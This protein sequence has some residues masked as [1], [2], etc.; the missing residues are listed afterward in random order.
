MPDES[1]KPTSPAEESTAKHRAVDAERTGK[2][3]PVGRDEETAGRSSPAAEPT[4][5]FAPTAGQYHGPPTIPGYDIVG[6]LGRGG[7]G[8]VC[9]AWHL[10]TKRFVALKTVLAG[11]A[12]SPEKLRRFQAEAEAVARLKHPNIIQFYEAGEHEGRPFFALEFCGGGT[13]AKKLSGNP[14]TARA[15]AVLVEKL[16]QAVASAHAA[17]VIHRDLKPAN[18]LLSSD[19]EPKIGD[20][21]LA[22]RLDGDE[23]QTRAGAVIGTP[24][25]MPP[26]QAMA[27]PKAA[28]PAADIYALGAILYECLTGRAPFRGATAVDTLDQVRH[29]KPVPPRQ[30][31]AKIP[32]DL[33]TICLKCL[34]KEPAKRYG[35]AQA[36][37]EDLRRFLDGQQ[38]LAQP[39]GLGERLGRWAKRQP[40]VAALLVA[41]AIGLVG[42]AA[43]GVIYFSELDRKK[44]ELEFTL[45]LRTAALE[46]QAVEKNALVQEKEK[47]LAAEY[48]ILLQSAKQAANA[49]DPARAVEILDLCPK[50]RRDPEWHY[51][52]ERYRPEDSRPA[53]DDSDTARQLAR[54]QRENDLESVRRLALQ[55]LSD[56]QTARPEFA[57][58]LFAVD[59]STAPPWSAFT[60]FAFALASN[61]R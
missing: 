41:L 25:Y 3:V 5:T 49:G 16:A 38:T 6:E 46:Q 10:P 39:A 22:K 18:V 9:K 14:M 36:L 51:L 19:G 17:Q 31:E 44:R 23:V 42:A 30:F 7:M 26:E 11:A 45:S 32:R 56:R 27:A 43:F 28:G 35:S 29:Q 40:V 13:L 58:A 48:S 60:E 15:A 57:L 37:A 61:A 33:D 59:L 52:R 34:S 21:G 20:F 2:Y 47:A 55:L 24:S 8:V 53:T 12:A 1:L 54:A 4:A 50:N